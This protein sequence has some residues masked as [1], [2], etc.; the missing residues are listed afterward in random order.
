L[1]QLA[2]GGPQEDE[3]LEGLDTFRRRLDIQT[4]PK[5]GD[6]ADDRGDP[7]VKCDLSGA[8]ELRCKDARLPPLIARIA[9]RQPY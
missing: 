1:R 3:L 6:D 9:A 2:T 5:V 4:S 7:C 8:M